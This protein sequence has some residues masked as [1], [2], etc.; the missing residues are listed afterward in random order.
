MTDKV[1]Y[2]AVVGSLLHIVQCTQPDLALAVGALAAC[3][4]DPSV[5]HHAALVDTVRYVN[6]TASRGIA[7]VLM[8]QG[9]CQDILAVDMHVWLWDQ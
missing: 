2:Q 7:S 1:A 9:E 3:C 6:C 4:A 8:T 5:V